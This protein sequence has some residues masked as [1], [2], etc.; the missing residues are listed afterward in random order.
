MAIVHIQDETLVPTDYLLE[1]AVKTDIFFKNLMDTVLGTR[2]SPLMYVGT[3]VVKL[4]V[5]NHRES[6]EN[7]SE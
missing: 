4:Q 3:M 6:N 7:L 5:Y 2:P 1:E